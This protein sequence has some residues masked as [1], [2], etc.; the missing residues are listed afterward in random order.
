MIK[1]AASILSADFSCLREE[2]KKAEKA[3]VDLIH[4][5][6]MDGRFV[7]NIT[8]GPQLVRDIRKVSRI[9]FDVHLM[10]ENPLKYIDDFVSAG[11][12]ML[13]LHIEV[14]KASMIKKEKV[15]L[16]KKG[17]KLGVS[18]NPATP[19]S[20]IKSVLDNIDL[21]LVMTVNPGF[22][23]Q[24]FIPEVVP[25]IK[26]LRRIYKGIISVDGGI[27][28]KNAPILVAAGVDILASGS[29]LFKAKDIKEAIKR[30][31]NN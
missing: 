26:E 16:N 3:G 11:A 23:G 19:L 29:Y 22:G 27:N 8:F 30:L 2:I 25:K 14:T 12:D 17:I 31:R 6:V 1:I 20:K 10:I 15:R 24:E 7:P 9:P 13:T 4:I 5:D 28:D 21:V 18:L